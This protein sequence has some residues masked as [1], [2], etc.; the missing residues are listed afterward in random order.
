MTAHHP[1]LAGAVRV[2]AVVVAGAALALSATWVSGSVQLADAGSRA[3]LP[4]TSSVLVDQATVVC[5]GQQRLGGVGLRDV[6]GDVVVAAAAPPPGAVGGI[7][8]G[9][10]GALALQSGPSAATLASGNDPGRAVRASVSTADPVVVRADGTMAPGLTATEVWLHRGDDD[11]GLAVTPCQA[12]SSDV[13]LIGGG[14]GP[15]R[16]ERLIVSNPGANAVSVGFEVF[17][18][19]GPVPGAD[20]HD[21]S[22]PPLSRAVVS[23]DALAPD[24][25][26]PVVHV[27]ATGGVVSAVLNE[28]WINGATARG[29]DDATRAASP[30]TNLVVAGV[31]VGGAVW[32]RI[33][34]PGDS[35]ALVQVRVL[36]EK[37]PVQPAALR[38][39]RVAPR[40]TKTVQIPVSSGAVGL[41]LRS[42]QP[43]VAGT[44]TERRATTGDRMGDFAW[45][46]ATPA[47][48][49]GAGLPLPDLSGTTK[50][51]LL[52]SGPEAA[53]A[54]VRIGSGREARTVTATV[55]ADSTRV[56]D[57]GDA[58][59]V[60]V[61]PTSGTL[62]G[63]VS[64][65]GSD[66]GVPL[67][68]VASLA[69]A[70]LRALSVPV[71]QVQN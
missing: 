1:V 41:A 2:G 66:S 71:R 65:I 3:G 15:S 16:T 64:V 38:A 60:W 7:P 30:G 20:D 47:L 4:E 44:W 33:G 42:D 58:D 63:A 51:L 25:T 22:I 10:S 23:L 59:A 62:R 50:R 18:A 12:A 55:P 48:R 8:S 61:V 52:T 27:T 69:D 37:G 19:R 21:V 24:E 56:V 67:Y 13:W 43:V 36:T 6:R 32:T 53:R 40:S 31:D 34:N 68:S 9:G 11:R 29:I 26:G 70:P 54:Q 39:V 45:V 5:P 17:G 35:E 14:T 46:A 49:G 28:Q 57:L